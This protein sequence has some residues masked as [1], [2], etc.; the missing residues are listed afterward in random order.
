MSIYICVYVYIYIHIYMA[1]SPVTSA[2]LAKTL[3]AAIHTGAMVSTITIVVAL[4]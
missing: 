3:I 4:P 1:A 2:S